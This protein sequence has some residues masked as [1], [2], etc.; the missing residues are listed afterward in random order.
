MAL[1]GHG[2]NPPDYRRIGV[3]VGPSNLGPASLLYGR[4][5]VP[6][7]FL[8]GRRDGRQ[9]RES[10]LRVSILKRPGQPRRRDQ[11]LLFPALA[12]VVLPLRQCLPE[13][14]TVPTTVA[15]LPTNERL[16]E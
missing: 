13:V 8:F 11:G 5:D 15:H 6:N 16:R 4:F 9:I 7:E 10:S 2:G 14:E 12:R 1:G 3:G